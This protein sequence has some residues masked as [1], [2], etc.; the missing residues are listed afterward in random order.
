MPNKSNTDTF[1]WDFD[2][3]V[4][5]LL[6]SQLISD[7][8]TAIIELVKNSYDANATEVKIDF[9]DSTNK[10]NGKIIIQDNGHGMNKDDIKN[11]WMKIGTNSKRN[12][13]LSPKPFNRILLGEKGIGRFAIEKLANK[14]TL[15]S[16]TDPSTVIH[17]LEIDW[18]KYTKEISNINPSLF[19]NMLNNYTTPKTTIS[20]IH[21]NGT[22]LIFE[23]L[24]E[25]WTTTD[26]NRLKRELSKL[27]SPF[28]I[29]IKYN[30]FKLLVKEKESDVLF[31]VN[32][33]D[34]LIN[35]SLD[36]AS[37]FFEIKYN[38][39]TNKQEVLRFNEEKKEIETLKQERCD[40]GPVNLKLYWFNSHAK[41]NFKKAYEGKQFKIDGFKIYRDGVLTTPFVEIAATND[42]VDKYRD[43]LGIDKRRW[44]NFFGKISSH[45][46]IGF[47]EISKDH[48]KEIRDLTNRQDFEDTLQY[49]NFKEFI[50]KQLVQIEKVLEKEKK[51][52]KEQEKNNLDNALTDLNS[53][54][55]KLSS[56]KK[57]SPEIAKELHPALEIVKGISTTIRESVQEIRTLEK[58][59]QHQEDVYFSLMSLQEYAADLAHMVK[60]SID[61]IIGF[62]EF[63]YYE[64]KDT[65]YYSK[66]KLIHDESKKLNED[67]NYM[68][69]YAKAG[70]KLVKF[71]VSVLIHDVFNAYDYKFNKNNISLEIVRPEEFIIVHN[72][73]LLR[74]VF[75]N[76]INNSIKALENID[77]D[78]IIKYTAY[79]DNNSYIILF[80]DNGEGIL[81]KHKKLIFDRYFTTTKEQKGSGIGLYIV[82]NNLKTF[83]ATIELIESEFK[84]IGTTFKI[85]IPLKEKDN[86]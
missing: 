38:A 4:F 19:T 31:D 51:E 40:F 34:N 24:K 66:M 73:T 15:E 16:I 9:I 54:K 47:I 78:K 17:K 21:K 43:I 23:D 29:K 18:N 35:N 62:S 55:T 49:R 39:K 37:K 10:Q 63:L 3:N 64:L 86:D 25:S 74:D 76:L 69:D 7:K 56:L 83:N 33:Y 79:K 8:F 70:D 71:D 22:A 32:E 12:N 65:E 5:K 52:K 20:D 82:R 84:N 68:L 48:N 41:R 81:E 61:K 11:K 67:V 6:G 60:N 59:L 14:I 72:K 36:Y 46:F 77:R 80:S 27:I 28:T 57:S 45:D 75:N 2:V 13:K 50:I 58:N 1:T 53:I 44:S 42:N 30:E 26:I 85:T